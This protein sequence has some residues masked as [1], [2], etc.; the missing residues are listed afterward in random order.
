MSAPSSAA[1]LAHRRALWDVIWQ[2]LLAWVPDDELDAEQRDAL[3]DYAT[4]RTTQSGTVVWPVDELE[5]ETP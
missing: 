4:P 5:G 1:H 2:T 3:N